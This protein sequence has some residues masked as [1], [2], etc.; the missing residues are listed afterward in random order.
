[1][2]NFIIDSPLSGYESVV[3]DLRSF[4]HFIIYPVQIAHDRCTCK[5]VL[6]EIVSHCPSCGT[7]DINLTSGV[8]TYDFYSTVY[9]ALDILSRRYK[10]VSFISNT[11]IPTD[12]VGSLNQMS[13][14]YVDNLPHRRNIL[15]IS[16]SIVHTDCLFVESGEQRL[17]QD[18][19]THIS[20]F[21]T[22]KL[23]KDFYKK[24]YIHAS[25]QEPLDYLNLILS[26]VG[27]GDNYLLSDDDS[28]I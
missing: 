9:K 1:M 24:K 19:L 3:I 4:E 6:S 2:E 8:P 14:T 11:F 15:H 7:T 16:N 13:Y 5:E 28:D 18:T 12:F 23:I 22:N 25:G 20:I 17:T 10:T 26:S 27:L 21:S